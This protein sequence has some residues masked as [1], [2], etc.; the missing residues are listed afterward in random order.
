MPSVLNEQNVQGMLEAL[1]YENQS[2]IRKRA[3]LNQ[4]GIHPY[5]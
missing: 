3:G 2:Y 4:R 5:L 1:L